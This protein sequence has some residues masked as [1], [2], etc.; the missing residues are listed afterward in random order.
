MDAERLAKALGAVRSGRQWKCKCVSHEDRSPSMII[1]DGRTGA[2]QVR[3]MAGCEPAD[4]I[5]VLKSRGLW[6]SEKLEQTSSP[7]KSVSREILSAG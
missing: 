2:V 3:C 4:I 5:A 7:R 1:F 6:H